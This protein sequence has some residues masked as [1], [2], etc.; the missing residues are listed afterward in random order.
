VESL[1]KTGT[2]T[3]ADFL[4]E[5]IMLLADG[6]RIPSRIFQ[7]RSL[8]VGDVVINN[9]TANVTP[10]KRG[11]LLLGQSFLQRLKSWSLDNTRHALIIE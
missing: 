4:G 9:V 6:S 3:N 1:M 7:L 8:K 5:G 2:V 10:E 11:A